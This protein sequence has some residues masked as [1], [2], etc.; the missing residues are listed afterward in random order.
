MRIV[1]TLLVASCCIALTSGNVNAVT[2]DIL[3]CEAM[4]HERASMLT[5][6][7][8]TYQSPKAK[9]MVPQEQ[10][11]NQRGELLCVL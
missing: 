2:A 3:A 10:E 6:V 11:E 4:E 5:E 9:M 7:P 1:A 8:V